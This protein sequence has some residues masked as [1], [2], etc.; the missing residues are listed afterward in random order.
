MQNT[1]MSSSRRKFLPVHGLTASMLAQFYMCALTVNRR[2]FR[3][4]LQVARLKMHGLCSHS[5]SHKVSHPFQQPAEGSQR[6]Q[7]DSRQH[8]AGGEGGGRHNFY[9]QR[10]NHSFKK[11]IQSGGWAETC[12]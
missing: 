4:G 7:T 1:G 9:K 5:P 10:Q 11:T 3:W 2:S 8:R 12:P 6:D